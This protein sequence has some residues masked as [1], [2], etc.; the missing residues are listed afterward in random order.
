VPPLVRFTRLAPAPR[1]VVTAA[2]AL[3]LFVGAAR[4]QG[5]NTAASISDPDLIQVDGGR[6]YTLSVSGILS[7]IDL[8]RPAGLGLL[9]QI[10]LPGEPCGM[11]RRGDQL[12]VATNKVRDPQSTSRFGIVVVDVHDPA[13]LAQVGFFAV[14][15]GIFD[16]RVVGNVLYL[17]TFAD[18]SAPTTLRSFDLTDQTGLRA[19]DQASLGGGTHIAGTS[20]RLIVT[21][22]SYQSA[23]SVGM[24]DLIDISDGS[25]H[26][27]AGSRFTV[28][29]PLYYPWQLDERDAVLRV[30]SQRTNGRDIA[31]A[32][33]DTFALQGNQA[34][35]LGHIT[36]AAP[37]SATLRAGRFDGARAYGSF[38]TGGSLVA[39]DLSDPAHP[40]QRGSL[41]LSGFMIH[42]EP[43]GERLLGLGVDAQDPLGG[44]NVSLLDV[45]DSASPRL[46]S[47]VAF[48]TPMIDVWSNVLHAFADGDSDLHK[49]FTSFPDGRVAV[50]FTNLVQGGKAAAECRNDG[51]GVQLV[52][53]SGDT[54][55]KG[56]LL[57]LPGD[58]RRAFS[59]PDEIVAVS[60]AEVRSFPVTGGGVAGPIAPSAALTVGACTRTDPSPG[61][62]DSCSA[63]P[64]RPSTR[65]RSG[66][67][68][69]TLI[70]LGLVLALARTRRRR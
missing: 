19:I 45:A 6:L 21:G 41:A 52:S 17:V 69:A 70:S 60:D 24:I 49:V 7:V 26:L 23:L 30:M 29:G 31:P 57:P 63:A 20:Q 22:V 54:L 14:P 1:F 27:R 36:I 66:V 68:A 16:S 2:L 38:D 35:T 25:G 48:A 53:W 40:I 33:L 64:G 5:S 44:L 62:D 46:L 37:E 50:P 58:P 10:T 39:V 12:L 28:T 59:Q 8:S 11:H 61:V 56:A 15:E 9:G 4:G 51:G 47:R 13:H 43:H 34:R 55:N 3:F 67:P 18:I 42:L 32:E 65:S